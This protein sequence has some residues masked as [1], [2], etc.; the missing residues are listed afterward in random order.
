MRYDHKPRIEIP[1]CALHG[2]EESL[3]VKP[4]VVKY[5]PGKFPEVVVDFGDVK[6]VTLSQLHKLE[7]LITR[8]YDYRRAL[9]CHPELRIHHGNQS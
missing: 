8:T 1:V 9:F 3:V 5:E 6:G 2:D 4:R 7:D